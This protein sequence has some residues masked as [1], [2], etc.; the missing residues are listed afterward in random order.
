MDPVHSARKV[1]MAPVGAI[2][3]AIIDDKRVLNTSPSPA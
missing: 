3:R 2:A 1:N